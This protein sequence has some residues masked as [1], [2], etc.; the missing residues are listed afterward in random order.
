MEEFLGETTDATQNMNNFL[1]VSSHTQKRG[2]AAHRNVGI[3][4]LN[5]TTSQLRRT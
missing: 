5:N 3:E 4:Y 1:E 2:Q